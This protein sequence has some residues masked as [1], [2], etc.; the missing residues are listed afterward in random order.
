MAANNDDKQLY[1]NGW[2]GDEP[3]PRPNPLLEEYPIYSDGHVVG[4]IELDHGVVSDTLEI[5]GSIFKRC[6]MYPKMV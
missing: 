4:F 3:T 6:Q 1:S 2:S 5:R